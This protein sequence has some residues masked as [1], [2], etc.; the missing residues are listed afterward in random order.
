M[1]KV[2]GLGAGGGRGAW[3]AGPVCEGNR[4]SDPQRTDQKFEICASVTPHSLSHRRWTA[5]PSAEP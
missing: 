1:A 3:E 4:R 5:A 2:T